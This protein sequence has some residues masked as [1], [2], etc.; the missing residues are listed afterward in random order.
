[1]SN[2]WK[3]QHTDKLIVAIKEFNA[4]P[5]FAEGIKRACRD[6]CLKPP[7]GKFLRTRHPLMHVGNLHLPHMRVQSFWTQLDGL[8][9]F[10]ILRMLKYDGLAYA[11]HYGRHPI[12][13]RDIAT[14]CASS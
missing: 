13:L 7:D 14:Q 9:L 8:V 6:L 5:S 3:T 12:R 1:L 10:L 2:N 11:A 4:R